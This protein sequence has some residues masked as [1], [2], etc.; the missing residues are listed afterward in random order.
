[1]FHIMI[2]AYWKDME[3]EVPPVSGLE[4]EGWRQWIDTARESPE[5]ILSWDETVAVRE[6]VYP[7]QSRSLVVLVCWRAGHR[8]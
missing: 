1:M 7:V 3:F 6:A 8:K 2:N 5:D 4:Y